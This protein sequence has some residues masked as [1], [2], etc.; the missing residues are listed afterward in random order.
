[1]RETHIIVDTQFGSCGKGLFSGFLA[2]RVNPDAIATGWGPNAGHTY[3]TADGEKMVVIALPNGMVAPSV[4]RILIGPGS[5]INPAIF[6][7]EM[8]DHSKWL[9]GKDIMIHEHAAVV[10]DKHRVAEAGAMFKIGST[11]KGVGEAVIQKIRRDPK[12]SNIASTLLRGTGL[13]PLVVTTEQYNTAVDLSP[14]V[15]V[16]G[17][18]GFSLS[19]NQGF[20][21]YTTSR[22]CTTTQVLTDCGLPFGKGTSRQN[23]VVYGVCRTFPIRVANRFKVPGDPTSEQIGWSGPCYFDQREMTWEEV[24]QPVEYTTVTKLPRRVFSF[25]Q[26]Q[27]RQAV[28]MNGIDRVFINF[29]NYLADRQEWNNSIGKI[30]E[31]LVNRVNGDRLFSLINAIEQVGGKV[32]WLGWGPAHGDVQEL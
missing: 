17:H 9:K 11:M 23:T 21:P 15:M 30:T 29:A 22:D 5:I 10:T 2:N 32:R 27:I 18:Q 6:M 16:E 8:A 13:E 12:N 20:Y 31:Q 24:G 28:R 4:K 25:S 19:M 7:K 1:M 3:I 14:C 26:E